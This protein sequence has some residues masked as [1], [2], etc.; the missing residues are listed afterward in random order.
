[1]G[2]LFPSGFIFLGYYYTLDIEWFWMFHERKSRPLFHHICYWKSKDFISWWMIETFFRGWKHVYNMG[3][4]CMHKE[5]A[6][7]IFSDSCRRIKKLLLYGKGLSFHKIGGGSAKKMQI[8]WLCFLLCARL[9]L[10]FHKIGGG[11][12]K[13]KQICWLCFL[14]CA[15]LALSLPTIWRTNKKP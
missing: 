2:V 8:R 6:E 13:K 5:V 14:L 10:S 4:K 12:A 1:M 3:G 9:A 15:R 7:F 11:S